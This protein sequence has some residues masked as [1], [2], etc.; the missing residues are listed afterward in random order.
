VFLPEALLANLFKIEYNRILN[1]F[2]NISSVIAVLTVSIV[3]KKQ[4]VKVLR[5]WVM[6]SW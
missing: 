1:G 6:S 4:K 3:S 2:P 5:G